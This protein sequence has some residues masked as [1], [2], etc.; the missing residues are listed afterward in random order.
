MASA[1]GS[2]VSVEGV[3]SGWDVP[4]PDVVGSADV[5]ADVVSGPDVVGSADVLVGSA[6]V[7]VGSAE[8]FV[9]SADVLVGSAEERVG[10]TE[11]V[12]L[13]RSGLSVALN[14]RDGV[15][16]EMLPRS[17]GSPSPQPARTR[18]DVAMTM[19]VPRMPRAYG[20][21]AA[22]PGP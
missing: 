2:P 21:G 9:G 20:E 16:L 13:G 22:R 19:T 10:A 1:A 14:V 12:G 11:P 8:V 17:G 4:S 3:T 15:T 18:R 5:G 6:D 7:L